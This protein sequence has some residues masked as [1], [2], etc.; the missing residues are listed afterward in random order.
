MSILTVA[1]D[2][3]DILLFVARHVN[4][5]CRCLLSRFFIITSF[6]TTFLEVSSCVRGRQNE[7]STVTINNG[8]V[9]KHL[10]M[11]K[12]LEGCLMVYNTTNVCIIT[13]ASIS[14]GIF[15]NILINTFMRKFGNIIY[16]HVFFLPY[17]KLNCLSTRSHSARAALLY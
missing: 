2:G 8:R 11:I 4:L 13:I 9:K 1:D 17:P 10:K 12:V 14:K 15:L 6:M 16:Y 3:G 5:E 7:L